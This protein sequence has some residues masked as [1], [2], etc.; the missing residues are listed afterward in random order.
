MIFDVNVNGVLNT[1]H[2]II[3]RM[4][5][6]GQG[7]LA[8]MSSLAAYHPLPG[9]PAYSASKA[10]ILYYAEGLNGALKQHGI[11]VSAVCP[12][13][14]D[15]PLT[16]KNGFSMPALLRPEDAAARIICGLQQRNP[17]ISFP[18]RLAF[19]LRFLQFLPVFLQRKFFAKLPEK[20]SQ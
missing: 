18:K 15:T 16:Q 6:R 12:G 10:A 17:Q 9:A 2:P 20:G 1:I 5:Q 19:P 7:Q 11:S 4:Q 13:F 3:P 14:V 8:L